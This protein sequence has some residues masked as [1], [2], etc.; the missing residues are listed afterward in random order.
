MAPIPEHPPNP[1]KYCSHKVAIANLA[2]SI[3]NP[4]FGMQIKHLH[5]PLTGKKGGKKKNPR[6]KRPYSGVLTQQM[7]EAREAEKQRI[8]EV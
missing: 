5:D 2:R 8:N 1:A 6:K 7:I 4:G 3:N